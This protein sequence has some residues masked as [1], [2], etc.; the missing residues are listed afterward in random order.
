MSLRVVFDTDTQVSPKYVTEK[1]V[2]P[3]SN[4]VG[5]ELPPPQK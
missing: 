5:V 3:L 1:S 2:L 4:G